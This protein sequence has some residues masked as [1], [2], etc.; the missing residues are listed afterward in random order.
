MIVFIK[1]RN[2]QGETYG[3]YDNFWELV[4]L[5]GFKTCEMDEVDWQ[6][7]NTYIY[8]VE[9]GNTEANFSHNKKGAKC[10]LI[11]WQLEFPRW[12]NGVIA[13]ADVPDYVDE[14]WCSDKYHTSLFSK[15]KYVFLGGHADY[16]KEPL[17][18]IWDICHMSYAYGIRKAK[19]QL[20]LSQGHTLAPASE[21]YEEREHILRHS[22]WGVMLHQNPMAIMTPLRAVMF[23]SY[24]LP[25]IADYCKASS[26]YAFFFEPLLHFNLNKSELQ[27]EERVK[28]AVKLNYEI[29]TTRTFRKCVEEA[30]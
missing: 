15:A 30:V 16:G 17:E 2:D 18:P 23:A 22:K 11:F 7:D 28:E 9:N 24:R 3:S 12:E 5:S 27:D 10:K 26:P 29:V 20:L 21:I 13:G 1:I 19:L 14:V 25:I 8:S 6:S 4:E